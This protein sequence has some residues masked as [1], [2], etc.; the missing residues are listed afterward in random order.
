MTY[1]IG[2]FAMLS[3]L[4]PKTLRF[5][6]EIGLLQPAAVDPCSNYRLYQPQQLEQAAAI[7]AFKELGLPLAKIRC[8]IE[9]SST[10]PSGL[11]RNRKKR[12]LEELRDMLTAS[13]AETE[14]SLNRVKTA[15]EELET[16]ADLTP[17]VVRRQAPMRIASIRSVLPTYSDIQALE[18]ALAQFIPP[19]IV[20]QTRGVLWHRC[21]SSGT[22]EGEA[23]VELNRYIPSGSRY[24]VRSLPET[25][26]ACA[27]SS[28]DD[29]AAESAYGALDRWLRARSFEA[30]GAKREIYHQSTLEIQY[31]LKHFR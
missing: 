31:P 4:S 26:A 22:L 30:H 1:R 6:D 27:Y 25:T 5:Y 11:A 20:G 24:I 2:E 15:I 17:V 19:D 10:T 16:A 14:Q 13:L 9:R 12:L 28:M 21:A 23:F 7:V 8:A 3:G 18:S 29:A